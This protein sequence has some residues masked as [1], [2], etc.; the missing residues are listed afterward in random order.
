MAVGIL[1]VRFATDGR[2]PIAT[3]VLLA[4]AGI[5]LFIAMVLAAA[6]AVR[7]F[8]TPF[9]GL[10]IPQMRLIHGTINAVGFG[11]CGVIAWRSLRR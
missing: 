3:R 9:P 6:Y 8:T 2:Q 7:S 11:L 4:V 5:S 10:G 1:H